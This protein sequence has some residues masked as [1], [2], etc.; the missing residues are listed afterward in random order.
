MEKTIVYV[1][2]KDGTLNL[3]LIDIDGK[4]KRQLT[5]FQNGEQVFNPKFS[6]DGTKI[7]FDYS[8]NESR[9][10][11]ICDLDGNIEFIL[12]EKNV[13]ERNPV[14]INDNEIIYSSDKKGIYNLFVYN[15][16]TKEIRQITNV[17]GGAFMPAYCFKG[18]IAYAGY[19]STGYKIFH[20]KDF[21]TKD[22]SEIPPYNFR[23]FPIGDSKRING[24][25]DWEK[26]QKF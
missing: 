26:T 15:L 24:S 4:N 1:S 21:E 25:F 6:P 16:K 14:F 19:T 3:F 11:A 20:I 2:Q 18:E 23:L 17:I 10:I 9:D 13:D 7:I 12:A 5:F 8:L 22:F